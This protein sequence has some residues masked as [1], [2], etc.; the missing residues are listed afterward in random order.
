MNKIKRYEYM[1]VAVIITFVVYLAARPT[2]LQSFQ[3]ASP[4]SARYVSVT[5]TENAISFVWQSNGWSEILNQ[6]EYFTSQVYGYNMR[7]GTIIDD[8]QKTM[9][10]Q[11]KFDEWVPCTFDG[12]IRM[13][14]YYKLNDFDQVMRFCPNYWENY[15]IHGQDCYIKVSPHKG[16]KSGN[17]YQWYFTGEV[18]FKIHP[19]DVTDVSVYSFI[20]SQVKY[21]QPIKFYWV[22]DK[23][24][25]TPTPQPPS[26]N[27]P[28]TLTWIHSVVSQIWNWLTHLF[29]FSIVSNTKQYVIGNTTTFKVDVDLSSYVDNNYT[30]G[31]T[32]NVYL[33]YFVL[34]ENKDVVYYADWVKLN[35]GKFH[36]YI[37]Y[38]PNKVGKYYF[39]VSAIQINQTYDKGQSKWIQ[40]DPFEIYKDAY[41]F[42]VKDLTPPKPPAPQTPNIFGWIGGILNNIWS[43]II[44]LFG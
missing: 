26:P 2:I 32:S 9:L 28:D 37:S 38:K 3:M 22:V 27:P 21:T 14:C 8:A 11:F 18:K 19:K 7:D 42:D 24:Q 40:Q 29:S 4:Y 15:H 36:K 13:H 39:V 23:N 33:T 5:P 12:Y 30:D 34:N 10:S 35:D 17:K 31:K 20:L 43:W 1:L 25:N 44:K 6:N 41:E 16:Y